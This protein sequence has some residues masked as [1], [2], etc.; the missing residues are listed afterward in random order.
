MLE[1]HGDD[2]SRYT[3]DAS[4]VLGLPKYLPRPD[5]VRDFDMAALEFDQHLKGIVSF[6]ILCF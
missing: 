4:G 5:N 3:K 6:L 1:I 2:A